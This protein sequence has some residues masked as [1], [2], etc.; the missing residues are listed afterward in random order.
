MNA[1]TPFQEEVEEAPAKTWLTSKWR[2]IMLIVIAVDIIPIVYGLILIAKAASAGR[3]IE[4]LLSY[5][6]PR[7]WISAAVIAGHGIL[8]VGAIGLL[9]NAVWGTEAV[10]IGVGI[11]FVFQCLAIA[12]AGAS[13]IGDMF[14]LGQGR[15]LDELGEP[16]IMNSGV[17]AEISVDRF[18]NKR[19]FATTW[20]SIAQMVILMVGVEREK[21]E[22]WGV[23][24]APGLG[25]PRD[26]DGA[27]V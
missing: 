1:Q 18:L 12:I 2:L 6:D 19:M 17:I 4:A 24:Q 9:M 25:P 22:P 15:F 10:K 8:L 26:R 13:W 16:K 5:T 3:G 14:A 7:V 27:I 23:S 20:L 11:V 21:M